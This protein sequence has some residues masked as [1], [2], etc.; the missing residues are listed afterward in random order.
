MDSHTVRRVVEKLIGRIRPTGTSHEDGN[1]LD[2]L[3]ELTS[4]IEYFVF[5]LKAISNDN[6]HR[7]EYSVKEMVKEAERCLQEL[8]EI[9]NN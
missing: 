7:N 9:V 3:K 4:L 5:N 1:R 2:N 8:K 6:K